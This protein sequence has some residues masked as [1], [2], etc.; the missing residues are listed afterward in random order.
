MS[1]IGDLL[2]VDVGQI[3]GTILRHPSSHLKSAVAE[4]HPECNGNGGKSEDWSYDKTE[5]NK[6]DADCDPS[7]NQHVAKTFSASN[8]VAES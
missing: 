8:H 7:A 6:R 3:P 1:D 2:P 4:E 5:N